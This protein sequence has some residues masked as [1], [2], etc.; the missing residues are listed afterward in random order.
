MK[1]S[2]THSQLEVIKSKLIVL[3][4]EAL[5]E[6]TNELIDTIYKLVAKMYGET[7]RA[8]LLEL[9]DYYGIDID[10]LLETQE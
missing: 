1:R 6:D 9:A 2:L 10:A 4:A 7:D 5:L 3:E 8:T